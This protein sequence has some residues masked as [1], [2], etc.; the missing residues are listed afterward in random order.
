MKPLAIG[1]VLALALLAGCGEGDDPPPPPTAAPGE[2]TATAPPDTQAPPATQADP[3][4][5]PD[6]EGAP[7]APPPDAE[8]GAPPPAW[9]ETSAGPMWLSLGSYCWDGS[10]FDILRATCDDTSVPAV[11]V[12]TGETVRFHL[13]FDPTS[14]EL[15]V[16][17]SDPELLD[18]ERTIDWNVNRAGLLWLSL[19]AGPNRR[20]AYQACLNVLGV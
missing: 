14:A 3:G 15:S 19:E 13:A 9:V 1:A 18:E 6:A 5:V 11:V 7:A 10:C 2:T 8:A 20:V 4:T 16:E 17:D 12:A